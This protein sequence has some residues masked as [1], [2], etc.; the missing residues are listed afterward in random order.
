MNGAKLSTEAVDSE[1]KRTGVGERSIGG[2]AVEASSCGLY[3][4]E[5]VGLSSENV[6]ENPTPRNPKV[7]SA[8]LVRGG[9]VRT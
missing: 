6:G 3:R 2:E 5:N 4:S 7:S 8:R 1:R 9:S